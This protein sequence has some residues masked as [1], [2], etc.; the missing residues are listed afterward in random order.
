MFLFVNIIQKCKIMEIK[1]K[2]ARIKMRKYFIPFKPK[3][4]T[5]KTLIGAFLSAKFIE[6]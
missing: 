3:K 6:L 2:D 5:D 1:N 4:P